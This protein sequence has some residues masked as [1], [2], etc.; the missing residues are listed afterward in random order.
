MPREWREKQVMPSRRKRNLWNSC[1]SASCRRNSMTDRSAFLDPKPGSLFLFS[2]HWECKEQIL[3][4]H[5][6][7]G[8]GLALGSFL[9]FPECLCCAGLHPLLWAGYVLGCS[10]L[11]WDPPAFWMRTG[12]PGLFR[13]LPLT[14]LQHA[15]QRCL[16]TGHRL[17]LSVLL[18]PSMSMLPLCGLSCELSVDSVF[19]GLLSLSCALLTFPIAP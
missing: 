2:L 1:R 10:L 4:R 8:P 9:P 12:L 11:P 7:G 19:A 18:G 16:P 13:A 3:Q 17:G 5:C 14:Q 15:P 6:L